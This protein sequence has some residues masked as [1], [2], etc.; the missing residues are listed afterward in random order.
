[1]IDVLPSLKDM[2]TALAPQINAAR[3]RVPAEVFIFRPDNSKQGKMLRDIL[4]DD[5]VEDIRKCWLVRFRSRRL[6]LTRYYLTQ[7]PHNLNEEVSAERLSCSR[8]GMWLR[9]GV[10]W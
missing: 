2:R 3:Q 1:M 8:R 9:L 5:G 4:R 6:T 10:E 7:R